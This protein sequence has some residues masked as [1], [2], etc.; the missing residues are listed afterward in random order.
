MLNIY[1]P[2]DSNAFGSTLSFIIM[3]L[4]KKFICNMFRFKINDFLNNKLLSLV[5]GK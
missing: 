1:T 4:F 5:F 2:L 3:S